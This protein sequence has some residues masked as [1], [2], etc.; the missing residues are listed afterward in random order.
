MLFT[1]Y[2]LSLRNQNQN[3]KFVCPL[4]INIVFM[5]RRFAKER[6]QKKRIVFYMHHICV[7]KAHLVRGKSAG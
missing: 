4:Y 3:I 7:Q 1:S 2:I 5:N 6:E